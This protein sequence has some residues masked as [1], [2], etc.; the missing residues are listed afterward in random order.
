MSINERLN[1]QLPLVVHLRSTC[2]LI[3]IEFGRQFNA[4][5]YRETVPATIAGIEKAI[6]AYLYKENHEEK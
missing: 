2:T 5:D 1:K 4:T 3:Y 6:F